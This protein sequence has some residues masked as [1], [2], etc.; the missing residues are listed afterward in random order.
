MVR[1]T[2]PI[3]LNQIK[4]S[5][6]LPTGQEVKEI[7]GW[8][9]VDN[10]ELFMNERPSERIVVNRA[11]V[12]EPDD[13]IMNETTQN[14]GPNRAEPNPRCQKGTRVVNVGSKCK[15]MAMAKM[16]MARRCCLLAI[17]H[18]HRNR[19]SMSE[20]QHPRSKI[21]VTEFR[22]TGKCRNFTAFPRALSM[23]TN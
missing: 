12:A 18:A 9:R 17:S 20:M 14:F 7:Q 8:A 13:E 11:H 23:Q 21:R 22:G 3:E 16:L 2:N 5:I 19:I 10:E 15:L 1:K 6:G 4:A